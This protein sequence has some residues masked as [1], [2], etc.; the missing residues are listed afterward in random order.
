MSSFKT[1]E[2]ES[3]NSQYYKLKDGDNRLR[4]VSDAY[5][6]FAAFEDGKARKYMTVEAA[7]KDDKARRRWMMWVIDRDD[8]NAIKLAEFGP[9]IMNQVKTL[10][11]DA[12]F[13]FDELPTYDFKIK[14]V[15]S[16]MESEYTVMALPKSDLTDKEKEEIALLESPKE[17]LRNDK[18]TLDRDQVAPF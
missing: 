10:A 3:N 14:K 7:S 13:G 8:K 1:L 17:I 15:G 12:D 6:L 11:L 5:P 2:T 9:Q 16:G 18:G 4:F